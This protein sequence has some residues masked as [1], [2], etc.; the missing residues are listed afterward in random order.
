MSDVTFYHTERA[1]GGRRTGLSVDNQRAVENFVPGDEDFNPT[2]RWFIDVACPVSAPPETREDA[3]A[4]LLAHQTA[5]RGALADAAERLSAGL[6]TP[7]PWTYQVSNDDGQPIRVSVSAQRRHDGTEIGRNIR[8]MLKRD[9]PA[10][11][12]SLPTAARRA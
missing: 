9:W 5:I 4:W 8:R 6:D 7:A 12:K 2:I 3:A 10:L 11:L 1:D